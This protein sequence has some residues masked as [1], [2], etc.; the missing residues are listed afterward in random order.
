MRIRLHHEFGA[1]TGRVH[2]LTQALIRLGRLPDNDVAFDPQADIDASGRHAEI[3]FE[4]GDYFV[5]DVGSRNGTFLNGDRIEKQ[6][7]RDGDVVEFGKGGPRLRVEIPAP[8]GG[9]GL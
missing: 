1:H 4:Q 2:E 9:A 7:L 3:R 6:K 5:M 8:T